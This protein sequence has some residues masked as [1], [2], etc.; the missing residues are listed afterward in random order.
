MPLLSLRTDP[1]ARF[2]AA[3]FVLLPLYLFIWY[4][5]APLLNWPVRVL[6]EMVL[7]GLFPGTFEGIAASG[8]RLDVLTYLPLPAD[9]ARQ[10]PDAAGGDL[11]F[12]LNPLVYSY[13][14][15]F[16]AALSIAMPG[17]EWPKWQ[18]FF[19]GLPWLLAA[20]VWGICFEATKSVLFEFGGAGGEL[21]GMPEWQRT[22]VALGY[23]LGALILP[24][25]LPAVLWLTLFRHRL[26]EMV[27]GLPGRLTGSD[28]EKPGERQGTPD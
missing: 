11:V 14:L 21:A 9:I 13:G 15:P 28:G 24:P 3:V 2:A 27:P 1:V 16:F 19:W 25:V 22:G 7:T 5:A 6:S 4:V 17:D 26:A 23:Q 20:H 18:R 8:N 12:T 10:M